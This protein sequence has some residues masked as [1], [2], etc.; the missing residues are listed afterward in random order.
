MGYNQAYSSKAIIAD[1]SW[2]FRMDSSN[3]NCTVNMCFLELSESNCKRNTCN[4]KP[5]SMN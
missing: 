1:W 3:G 4:Y 5:A 2:F